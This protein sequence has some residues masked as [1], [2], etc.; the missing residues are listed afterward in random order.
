[1]WLRSSRNRGFFWLSCWLGFP[2]LNAALVLLVAATEPAS[3]AAVA[4]VALALEFYALVAFA[5]RFA[6]PGV[7]RLWVAGGMALLVVLS[8]AAIGVEGLVWL[9]THY[10]GD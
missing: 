1:M 8:L 6:E 7:R 2:L 3:A 4:P 10:C 5:R 9:L